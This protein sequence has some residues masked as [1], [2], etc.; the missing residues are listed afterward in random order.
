MKKIYN[1]NDFKINEELDF[2]PIPCTYTSSDIMYNNI[3]IK[4]FE[5]L[6]KNNISYTIYIHLTTESNHLVENEKNPNGI[7]LQSI[8]GNNPIPT[9]Y[10]SETSRGLNYNTF[11]VLT[12]Y[13]EQMDVMG[14]IIFILNDYINSVNYKVFSIGR[15]DTN[16]YRFY[17][18]WLKNLPISEVL[19]GDSDNYTDTFG[20]KD[21]AYYLIR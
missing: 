9:I 7:F 18:Y 21:K 4:T 12:K 14:R 17:S 15:V 10:F 6:S 13:N 19:I 1:F 11:G 2:N 3:P 16:K 5:F 20:K 8:N